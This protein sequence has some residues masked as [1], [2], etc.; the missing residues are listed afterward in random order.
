MAV[1]TLEK[2]KPRLTVASA[3][4]RRPGEVLGV[5]YTPLIGSDKEREKSALTALRFLEKGTEYQN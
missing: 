3:Q 5:S 4:Q 2:V 1:Q